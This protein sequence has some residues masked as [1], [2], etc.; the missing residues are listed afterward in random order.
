MYV[1]IYSLLFYCNQKRHPP[2]EWR[3][4]QKNIYL[5]L[6]KSRPCLN[7]LTFKFD[8]HN[9]IHDYRKH[10]EAYSQNL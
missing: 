5:S 1:S 9:Y 3:L 2:K 10:N 7:F 6:L 4:N 8:P